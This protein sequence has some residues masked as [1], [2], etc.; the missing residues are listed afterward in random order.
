[1]NFGKNKLLNNGA[2][3]INIITII[4]KAGLAI[5]LNDVHGIVLTDFNY[6]TIMIYMVS[7]VLS[8]SNIIIAF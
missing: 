6:Y 7:F 3:V 5:I 8:C 4:I 2:W 1:M